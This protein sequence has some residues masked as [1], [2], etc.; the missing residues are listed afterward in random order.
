VYTI[1]HLL[2]SGLGANGCELVFNVPCNNTTPIYHSG[3]IVVEAKTLSFPVEAPTWNNVVNANPPRI[4]TQILGTFRDF[5]LG[6][7]T[8]INPSV[9]SFLPGEGIS[10]LAFIFE[11]PQSLHQSAELKF[12]QTVTNEDTVTGVYVNFTC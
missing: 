1:I 2:F 7:F 12:D 5:R 6:T 11:T 4:G 9:C 8:V 3:P 10:D